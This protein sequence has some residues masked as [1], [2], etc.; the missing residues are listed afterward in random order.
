V[1]KCNG[2]R[3]RVSDE[4]YKRCKLVLDIAALNGQKNLVLGAF[5]CGVFGNDPAEVASIWHKLLV[6]EHMRELFDNVEF[7][8]LGKNTDRNFMSFRTKFRNV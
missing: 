4:L 7:A 1:T 6:E 2:S 8:I 5:G 3:Q